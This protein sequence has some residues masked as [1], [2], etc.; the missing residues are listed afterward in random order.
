MHDEFEPGY[1]WEDIIEK[2][3]EKEIPPEDDFFS[4][5]IDPRQNDEMD[6]DL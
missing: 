6:E 1:D 4:Q 3:L 5:D 2:D